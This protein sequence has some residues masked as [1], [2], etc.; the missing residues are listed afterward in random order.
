MSAAAQPAPSADL[1]RP[2]LLRPALITDATVSAANG[3]V[4]LVAAGPVGDLLG[5]SPS[6]LR[7]LGAFFLGYAAFVALVARTPSRATVLLLVVGNLG[8]AVGSV[9]VAAAGWGDPTATGTAW[10]VL[11]GLI[12]GGF[13]V[14]QAIGRREL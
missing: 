12:V 10:I 11:Q 5:L 9:A 2:G 6:L 4:Y 7:G 3:L 1:A 8:W 13:G 14:A